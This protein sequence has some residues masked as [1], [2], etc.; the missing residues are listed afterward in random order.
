MLLGNATHHQPVPLCRIFPRNPN[1]VNFA[2]WFGF[3]FPTMV[4]LL[5]LSWLWLQILFL[6]FK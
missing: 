4:I 6:G 3:A 1:V 5:L 2:S